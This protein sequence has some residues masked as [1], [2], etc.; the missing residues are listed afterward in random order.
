MTLKHLPEVIAG[1]FTLGYAIK[2][3][4]QRDLLAALVIGS[5]GLW[6]LAPAL[7]HLFADNHQKNKINQL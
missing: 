1:G 4:S 2:E 5:C 6:V 7:I 3:V